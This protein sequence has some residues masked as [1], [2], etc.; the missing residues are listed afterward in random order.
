MNG[1]ISLSKFLS[2]YLNLSGDGL[3]KITHDQVKIL[4]P[5]IKECTEEEIEKNPGLLQSGD[6]LYVNDGKRTIAYHAPAIFDLDPDQTCE[7]TSDVNP[8][9]IDYRY[10]DYTSMSIYEL[11]MLLDRKF[12]CCRNSKKAKR[13]LKKRGA[14]LTRKYDRTS[15][16]RMWKKE[17][18][19]Y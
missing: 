16:K 4:F 13:E 12:N 6:V 11:K 2:R 18:E 1:Q 10:Y 5:S 17:S 7:V 9:H 8:T 3:G 14:I 19:R 15:E